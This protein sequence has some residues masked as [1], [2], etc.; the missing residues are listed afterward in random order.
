LKNRNNIKTTNMKETYKTINYEGLTR[1][2]GDPLAD[3][4]SNT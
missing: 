4:G 2:T 1:P 3:A